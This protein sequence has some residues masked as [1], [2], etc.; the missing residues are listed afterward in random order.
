MVGDLLISSSDQGLPLIFQFV[1]EAVRQQCNVN[2]L[3]GYQSLF[4]FKWCIFAY[5]F[6]A[7]SKLLQTAKNECFVKQRA[8]YARTSND[9]HLSLER[10]KLIRYYLILSITWLS[11]FFSNSP[12]LCQGLYMW[13]FQTAGFMSHITLR[14]AMCDAF[15]RLHDILV[16]AQNDMDGHDA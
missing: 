3:L 15:L 11:L 10:M 9:Y 14:S 2:T 13:R 8:S 5:H 7:M 6:K 16:R 4:A 1:L 12:A